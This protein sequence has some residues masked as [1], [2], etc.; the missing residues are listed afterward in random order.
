[1]T[2]AASDLESEEALAFIDGHFELADEFYIQAIVT[3]GWTT[4]PSSAA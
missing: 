3:R 1:M 4:S 2:A